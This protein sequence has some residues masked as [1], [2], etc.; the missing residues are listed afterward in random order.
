MSL[1]KDTTSAMDDIYGFTN[2]TFEAISK[3]SQIA[4]QT[5]ILSLNAAVEAATAGEAGKGFAVVAQEVRNLANRS[6]EVAKEIEGLMEVL[7]T[8]VQSGKNIATEMSS[9]L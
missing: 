2:K 7:R 4:F 3:I 1:A 6:A 8:K 9:R 5:N